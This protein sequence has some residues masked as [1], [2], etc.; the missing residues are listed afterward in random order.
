MS[1]VPLA[2]LAVQPQQPQDPLSQYAKVLQI[3]SLLGQQALQ[4]GQQ[5]IQQEQIKQQQIATQEDQNKV[6]SQNAMIQAWSDPSFT[7][8]ITGGGTQKGQPN[9]PGFDP[10]A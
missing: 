6:K 8:E 5:A 1:S 4:P 7:K 3:K 9:G 2:A 10:N